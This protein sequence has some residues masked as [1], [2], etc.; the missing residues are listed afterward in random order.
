M[1]LGLF[2]VPAPLPDDPAT[3]R[4]L[5]G[6]ALAE[7]ERLT[8]RISGLEHPRFGRRSEQLSKEAL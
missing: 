3:P 8:L 5:L 1:R 6:E 2:T 4:Q 7:I